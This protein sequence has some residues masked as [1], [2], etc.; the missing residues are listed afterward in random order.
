MSVDITIPSPGESITEV[1][2]GTW[3]KQSGDWVDK[4]EIILEI[5][6][7]KATLEIASPASGLLTATGATGDELAVGE[8]IGAIDTSA[9]KPAAAATAGA[10][11]TESASA[12]AGSDDVKATPVA[13]KIAADEGVNLASIKGTGPSGRVTKADVLAAR[14][15]APATTA[16]PATPP[17]SA[18]PAAPAAPATPTPPVVIPTS[19]TIPGSR[20]VRRVRMT[21]LRK[22]IAE[23][24]IHSQ[25]TAATLTTFNEVDMTRSMALRKEYKEAFAEKYGVGLG[26]MSFFVKA[27]VH[28]LKAQPTVNASIVDDEIEYHE[29]MDVG[30]AVGTEKGLVVPVLRNT[31]GMSFAEIEARIKDFAVRARAG[32]LTVEEMTGGTFTVSNGGVYGSMMS[33]PILNPPQ[34]GILGMHGIKKRAVEDPDNPGNIVLRP[35]MYIAMSYDHRIIDGTEAVTFLKTIKECVEAPER[36]LFDL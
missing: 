19:S 21:K 15:S 36:I 28:A 31:E 33:T 12:S 29:Y 17:P 9:T 10:A 13:R 24:L 32:K 25:H 14:S 1:T 20:E 22:R 7:D 23:R 4:D 3:M 6:S 27:A 30:V 11:T 34:S 16:A 8:V 35:M 5:E 26:F 18:A 2:V